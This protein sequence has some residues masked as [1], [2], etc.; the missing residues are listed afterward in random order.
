MATPDALPAA[1][2][3]WLDT[4]QHQQR[5]A[6]HTLAAY[7]RDLHHLCDSHPG[8][9]PETLTEKDIRAALARLHA[10]GLAPGSLARMLSAWRS[11]YRWWAPRAGMQAN[12]VQ[13]L[14]A[15]RRPQRLPQALSVDQMTQLLAPPGAA[16]AQTPVQW[17]DQAMFELFY[18]SGLRLSELVSLDIHHHH[19][20]A[21]QSRGWLD[22]DN[23]DVVVR[24]KG[25]R[26][27]RLPLGRIALQALHGWLA[28]RHHLLS[29]ATDAD[30]RAAL[31]LGLRGA[32]IHARVVQRQLERR[33]AACGLPVHVHPHGLRHSFASHLLQSAQDL[34]AVQ[35][36]LGHASIA[37][38]QIYT[39]LDFQHLAQVY[40]KAHPRAHRK[41]DADEG[42]SFEHGQ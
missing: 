18:S 19:D 40:D 36:L 39:R 17:R 29:D 24:G 30:S 37:T 31:F 20:A 5:Y 22:L 8:R 4:L 28:Q 2:A 1:M 12:P 10:Q 7:R 33:A 35:E 34:R 6:S 38:T 9:A 23:T 14:R 41:G 16:T 42:P 3:Q 15:P 32:R 25:G 26:T 13:G 11:F 21:H 27:R